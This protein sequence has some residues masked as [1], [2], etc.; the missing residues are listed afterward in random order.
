MKINKRLMLL[1]LTLLLL[2]ALICI[3]LAIISNFESEKLQT[4]EVKVQQSVTT[5]DDR[6]SLGKT[7][8]NM[9]TSDFAIREYYSISPQDEQFNAQVDE[10]ADLRRRILLLESYD[11]VY[12]FRVFVPDTKYYKSENINFNDFSQWDTETDGPVPG[13]EIQVSEPYDR[14][15]IPNTYNRVITLSQRI[16]HRKLAAKTVGV[17]CLDIDYDYLYNTISKNLSGMGFCVVSNKNLAIICSSENE[18]LSFVYNIINQLGDN[19]QTLYTHNGKLYMACALESTDWTI[20]VHL[21][22]GSFLFRATERQYST[23]AIMLLAALLMFIAGTILISRGLT[24]RISSLVTTTYSNSNE[25][26]RGLYKS[27]DTAIVEVQDLI[28]QREQS[29]RKHEEARLKLLQAQIN[30]HFLYNAMDT[31]R[32]MIANDEK[33]KAEDMVVAMSKYFRLILSQGKDVITLREEV[34]LTKLY[35]NLQKNRMDNTFEVEFDLPEETLECLIPKMILQPLLENAILHGLE[36]INK[37]YIYVDSELTDKGE[38]QIT[39]TD[40]GKGFDIEKVKKVLNGEETKKGFGLYNV[41]QR[42]QLFSGSTD[43][44]ITAETEEG[45]YAMFTILIKQPK[46]PEE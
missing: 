33:E 16:A 5:L 14:R 38:L 2:P 30:P 40:D 31:L 32:W 1:L 17:A 8:L 36:C 43:Y 28:I 26:P 20:I 34:E 12:S 41:Q 37:G 15:Y 24:R 3:L 46:E 27:L 23:M 39:V 35:I 44:G 13:A 10:L 25:V 11:V 42:I 4:S 29:I 7:L 45:K 6:I 21:G 18:D 9:F 22:S 19:R